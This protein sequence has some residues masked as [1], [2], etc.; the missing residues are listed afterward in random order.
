VV[1]FLYPGMQDARRIELVTNMWT[2]NAALIENANSSDNLTQFRRD[3]LTICR[4]AKGSELTSPM[5]EFLADSELEERKR[6]FKRPR[7]QAV[8]EVV[9]ESPTL[10]IPAHLS[11][12]AAFDDPD[13]MDLDH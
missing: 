13:A 1:D 3:M 2:R 6:G 8:E 9:E 4:E 11:F 7:T 10:T 12:P 5:I